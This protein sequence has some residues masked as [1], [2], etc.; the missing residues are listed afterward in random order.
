MMKGRHV[1]CLEF[2]IWDL[3]FQ[4]A[5]AAVA[6]DD[7]RLGEECSA[8]CRIQPAGRRR[9]PVD[10]AYCPDANDASMGSA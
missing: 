6:V 9:S 10:R 8:G 7:D 1:L 4:M 3:G 2:M 5:L